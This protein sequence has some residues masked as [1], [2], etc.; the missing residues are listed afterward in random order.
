M[1][2]TFHGG[3]SLV[4]QRKPSLYT[5]PPLYCY[6]V[7]NYDRSK[8]ISS[9]R[10]FQSQLIFLT[11]FLVKC[12]P[13]LMLSSWQNWE[14]GYL[15][16]IIISPRV[17]SSTSFSIKALIMRLSQNH[18]LRYKETWLQ[19][20]LATEKL[21]YKETWLLRNLATEKHGY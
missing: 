14:A 17:C 10:N 19:K 1:D 7:V 3:G 9:L 20:N 5:N 15:T 4:Q 18:K 2:Y 12:L 6:F 13:M 8:V 11:T 16:L 21:G